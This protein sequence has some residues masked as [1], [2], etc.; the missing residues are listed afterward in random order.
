VTPSSEP[1]PNPPR[2]RARAKVG[3]PGSLRPEVA[4]A[5]S[6]LERS[7]G[8]VT[9][10]EHQLAGSEDPAGGPG[11]DDTAGGADVVLVARVVPGAPVVPEPTGGSEAVEVPPVAPP[12]RR[13]GRAPLVAPPP[14]PAV[15]PPHEVSELGIAPPQPGS[16]VGDLALGGLTAAEVAERDRPEP[17]LDLSGLRPAVDGDPLATWVETT[18]SP[19][20]FGPTPE[21]VRRR[22][23]GR[24]LSWAGAVL[25]V[26][27]VAYLLIPDH[28]PARPTLVPDRTT[29]TE[30]ATTTT[31]PLGS[32][33][34]VPTLPSTTLPAVPA[35]TPTTA[36]PVKKKPTT[37]APRPTTTT[38][39]RPT[40]TTT[41]RPTTTTTAPT[42]TTTAHVCAPGDPGDP[43]FYTCP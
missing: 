7:I 2:L 37:T 32:Q 10:W 24:I 28:S 17:D 1:R 40:T 36:A 18:A 30:R 41:A 39:A 22:R 21:E 5:L 14:P 11:P 16:V 13:Q 33:F 31:A 19:H 26:A 25:L 34:S 20:R 35:T 12:S 6:G 27:A 29:T 23:N 42:T 38:T 43:P 8:E 15:P 4:D 9:D 3:T